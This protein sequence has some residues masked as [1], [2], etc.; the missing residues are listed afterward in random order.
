MF[1]HPVAVMM[2]PDVVAGHPMAVM[3]AEGGDFAGFRTR[4]GDAAGA[5]K[6]SEQEEQGMFHAGASALCSAESNDDAEQFL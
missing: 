2:P 3:A 1:R 4:G 6:D 5:Q